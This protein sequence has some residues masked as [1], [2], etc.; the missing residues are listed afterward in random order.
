MWSGGYGAVVDAFLLCDSCSSGPLPRSV[1]PEFGHYG[2]RRPSR[3]PRQGHVVSVKSGFRGRAGV[4]AGRAI[5]IS[6]VERR[7]NI[8]SAVSSLRS[9]FDAKATAAQTHG[10]SCSVQRI[11]VYA[12]DGCAVM[13]PG[14]MPAKSGCF[15][16]CPHANVRFDVCVTISPPSSRAPATLSISPYLNSPLLQ[17]C[18]VHYVRERWYFLETRQD[19]CR[20]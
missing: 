7:Y 6:R 4:L 3:Y 2:D 8:F 15:L 14:C 1:C 16:V 12:I 19:R 17:C 10:T 18:R 5:V 13:P 9:G 20:I 11:V